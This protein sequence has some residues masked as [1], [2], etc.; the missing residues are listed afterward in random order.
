MGTKSKVKTNNFLVFLLH[1]I[2]LSVFFNA[3]FAEPL[4]PKEGKQKKTSGRLVIDFS[5]SSEGYVMVKAKPS[6][7]KLKLLVTHD[8]IE[9]QYDLNSNGIYE[10][11]PLQ[12]GNG[13][14][15]FSLFEQVKGQNYKKLN[16]TAIQVDM[17]DPTR[18]FLYPNQYINYT[19]E[20]PAVVFA[21]E[22]C[23]GLTDPEEKVKKIYHYISVDDDK[24]ETWIAENGQQQTLLVER[25]SF[26]ESGIRS[27]LP[28]I[29]KVFET[30]KGAC[31]DVSGLMV[32][33]LRSVGVPAKY[34]VGKANGNEHAWVIIL[35]NDEELEIDPQDRITNPSLDELRIHQEMIDYRAERW[36]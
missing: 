35:I 20:T 24:T 5:N 10:V 15:I 1:L 36:Y 25:I 27:K 13:K 2:V 12:Y 7:K 9:L 33:M 8:G 21:Q 31:K 17:P 32:A 26:T 28:E 30:N 6:G 11:F 4:M 14:Y 3:C 16:S 23:E 18:C 34:V 19:A 22:L 29:D